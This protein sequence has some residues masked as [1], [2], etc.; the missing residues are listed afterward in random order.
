MSSC[1]FVSDL[2]F[3]AEHLGNWNYKEAQQGSIFNASHK[4]HLTY[5]I[6]ASNF[7]KLWGQEI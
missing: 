6:L 3:L 2:T 5:T 4:Q 1:I 7:L